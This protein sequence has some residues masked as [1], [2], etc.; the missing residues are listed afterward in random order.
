MS[1]SRTLTRDEAIAIV[2]DAYTTNLPEATAVRLTGRSA[3]WV[4]QQY[5]ALKRRGICPVAGQLEL[6][7]PADD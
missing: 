5:G 2:H 3:A 6:F 7:A 1:T 4:H